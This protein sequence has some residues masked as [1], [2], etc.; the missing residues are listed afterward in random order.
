MH[1]D[2]F[3][4]VSEFVLFLL[5]PSIKLDPWRSKRSSC[6]KSNQFFVKK[7]T[8][9]IKLTPVLF[10]KTFTHSIDCLL[11]SIVVLIFLNHSD[12]LA[13]TGFI[14]STDHQLTDP[15][16]HR[17]S[18]HQPADRVMI[19]KRLGKRKK[20]HFTEHK[21]R[22]QNYFGLFPIKHITRN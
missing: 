18:T 1:L 9:F 19:F 4:N 11:L 17:P 2:T 14:K 22:W 8:S 5:L 12:F 6:S 15:P 7:A 16:T 3:L 13:F 20:L 21:H 10:G